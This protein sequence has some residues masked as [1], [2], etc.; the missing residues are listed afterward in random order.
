MRSPK[1]RLFKIALQSRFLFLYPTVL[2]NS[3]RRL[4][5][6]IF[7]NCI[8]KWNSGQQPEN[9]LLFTW[10]LFCSLNSSSISS[11]AG[12][13]QLETAVAYSCGWWI[14]TWCT[15]TK[16]WWRKYWGN[17]H[18]NPDI[19]ETAYFFYTNLPSDTKPVNPDTETA[20]FW[21]HSPITV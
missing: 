5:S 17:A 19:F 10:I 16:S 2:A 18:S 4:K 14:Q 6:D 20:V 13:W 12:S 9:N 3:C 1:P 7:E 8:L 15:K 11:P 21:S